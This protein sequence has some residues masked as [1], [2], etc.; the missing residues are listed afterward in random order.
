MTVD[1]QNHYAVCY[2]MCVAFLSFRLSFGWMSWRHL[3]SK[4]DRIS[5][6]IVVQNHTHA[7]HLI[8]IF[9]IF[10]LLFTTGVKRCIRK[11]PLNGNASFYTTHFTLWHF[12]P[13]DR[14]L[15][16]LHNTLILYS[17]LVYLI[18]NWLNKT[19]HIKLK[20]TQLLLWWRL[21]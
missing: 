2:L 1:I 13:F 15:V 8:F 17:F 10:I 14:K 7:L 18:K 5:N 19:V 12:G 9:H 16:I 21:F 3:M 6:T 20:K 4:S 11:M